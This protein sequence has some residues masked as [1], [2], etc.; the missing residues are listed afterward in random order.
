MLVDVVYI[1]YIRAC[2]KIK[3]IYSIFLS[4]YKVGSNPFLASLCGINTFV[5]QTYPVVVC[6]LCSF[7]VTH[8]TFTLSFFLHL[9]VWHYLVTNVRD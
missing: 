3:Q 4:F 9:I 5:F 1:C 2:L 6:E 7:V 8:V